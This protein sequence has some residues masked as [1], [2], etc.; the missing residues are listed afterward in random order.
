MFIFEIIP[1][2]IFPLLNGFNVFCL[3]SQH[4]S[5]SVQDVFTNIFGGAENNEGLGLFSLTFNWQYIL[6][7][8]V[9]GASRILVHADHTVTELRAFL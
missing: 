9:P 1:S 5:P 2:Y 8:L 4:A 3:A 7:Q 6:S